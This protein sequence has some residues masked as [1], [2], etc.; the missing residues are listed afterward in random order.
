MTDGWS[1]G[2]R[3]GIGLPGAQRLTQQF[4]IECP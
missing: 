1:T 2:N 4:E 3:V